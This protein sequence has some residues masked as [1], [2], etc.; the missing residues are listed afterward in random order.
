V[1]L[2][3]STRLTAWKSRLRGV[4]ASLWGLGRAL[5]WSH[6]LI[7]PPRPECLGVTEH[8]RP[9]CRFD[10]LS[11]A[12]ASVVHRRNEGGFLP[13]R[14]SQAASSSEGLH[15]RRVCS[16]TVSRHQPGVRRPHP[17]SADRTSSPKAIPGDRLRDA[18]LP[19]GGTKVQTELFQ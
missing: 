7:F 6:P 3:D 8:T 2:D 14:A 19:A 5:V 18:T 4:I 13:A 10:Q 11:S 17:S 1:T 15:A 16:V 12:R 9:A